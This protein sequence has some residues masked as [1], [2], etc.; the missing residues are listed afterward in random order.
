[1]ATKFIDG[2][3]VAIPDEVIADIEKVIKFVGSIDELDWNDQD[4]SM[5]QRRLQTFLT[6]L[7]TPDTEV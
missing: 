4:V 2:N 5:A 6:T 7:T 3:V 1:M